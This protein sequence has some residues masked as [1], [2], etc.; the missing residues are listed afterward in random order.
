MHTPPPLALDLLRRADCY[1]DALGS[2]GKW[3]PLNHPQNNWGFGHMWVCGD[4]WDYAV[5]W[6]HELG[7]N[8][9]ENGTVGGVPWAM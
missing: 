2:Q 5:T 9:S 7:H 4:C 3:E 1:F 6:F 8:V